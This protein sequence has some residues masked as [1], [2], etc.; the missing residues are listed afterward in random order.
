MFVTRLHLR[1]KREWNFPLVVFLYCDWIKKIPH[2]TF[3]VS[4]WSM[5]TNSIYFIRLKK[6]KTS[7]SLENR[8]IFSLHS[9]EWYLYRQPSHLY[10]WAFHICYY[11][12]YSLQGQFRVCTL[13]F[14][15]D[16]G[17]VGVGAELYPFSGQAFRIS[18]CV[19]VS[20]RY[21]NISLAYW[22]CRILGYALNRAHWY[23]TICSLG[24]VYFFRNFSDIITDMW[25]NLIFFLVDLPHFLLGEAW[26]HEPA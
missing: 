24:W 10:N 20:L 12:A 3:G 21:L 4:H 8:N 5:S 23:T 19:V 9:N 2:T 22:V 25:S 11:I 7:S 26:P 13:L 1:S 18:P 6:G 15:P 17:K 16:A 14:I